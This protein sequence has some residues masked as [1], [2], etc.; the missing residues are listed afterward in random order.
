MLHCDHFILYFATLRVLK[1]AAGT[2]DAWFLYTGKPYL[3]SFIPQLLKWIK[4]MEGKKVATG[5]HYS[6]LS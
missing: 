3:L 4:E 1:A 5:M 6:A 2:K